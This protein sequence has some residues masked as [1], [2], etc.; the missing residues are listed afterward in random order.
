MT[1]YAPVREDGAKPYVVQIVDWG[2]ERSAIVYADSPSEAR[3]RAVGRRTV[4]VYVTKVRRA[5][6]EDIS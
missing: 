4:G 6:H 2:R 5:T 1:K 3:W